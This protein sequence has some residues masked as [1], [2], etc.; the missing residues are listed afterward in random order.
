METKAFQISL[1]QNSLITINVIPG[2][3]TTSNVHIN[4]YLDV[5]GLKSNCLAARNAAREL[6]IP[7]L[8]SVMIDTIVC[9]EGTEVI[10]AYLAEELLQEGNSVI[11]AGGEIHVVTPS[12]NISG[13]LIFNDSTAAWIS[14]KNILLLVATIS[15]G[16]TIRSAMECLS[17]Y[18]GRL[19][20]ISA[21]F[22]SSYDRLEQKIHALFTSDDIPGYGVFSPTE[23]EMCRAGQKLDAIISSEGYT[24][25][26]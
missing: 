13:K 5:S 8:S 14:G 26:G 24:K 15:S 22:I 2:H 1:E 4:N 25:I 12:S 11:N 18:N 20:G 6:A 10:G 17:Y 23:C 9:M 19:A 21:L 16:Q 7:Y 3:F